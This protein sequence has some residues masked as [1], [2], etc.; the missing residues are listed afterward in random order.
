MAAT[1]GGE[2]RRNLGGVMAVVVDDADASRLAAQLIAAL[3]SAEVGERRRD[4]VEGDAKLDADRNR[5]QGVL[6]VVTARDV[7]L[8]PLGTHALGDAAH[9]VADLASSGRAVC[10]GLEC[11]YVRAL[12]KIHR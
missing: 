6:E 3:D 1:R 4:P 9:P 12:A 2:H 10:F 11:P 5:R 7:E 8:E